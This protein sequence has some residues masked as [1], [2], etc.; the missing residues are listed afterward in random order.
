MC[1]PALAVGLLS[2]GLGVAQTVASYSAQRQESKTNADNSVQAWK[3]NQEQITQREMQE[4][5]ALRQKQTQQNIQEAQALADTQVSAAA[6]GVSG[7]SVDNLL[8]DVS[9]RADANRE[10]EQ[11][12]TDMVISQ[13]KQQRKGINSDAQSRINSVPEPSPLSLIAGIGSAGISGFN[14]YT[15]AKNRM[16]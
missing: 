9:R 13:L 4:Q 16:L 8:Q 11:T 10:T 14:S 5:D 3:N 1:N 12:N 2:A 6:S 15:S 7:I